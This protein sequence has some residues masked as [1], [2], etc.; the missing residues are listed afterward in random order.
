L[1]RFSIFE[2]RSAV[3]DVAVVVPADACDAA[4]RIGTWPATNRAAA[5]AT[6]P[7]AAFMVSVSL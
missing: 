5:T 4:A 1:I 7:M 2:S 6:L 3:D